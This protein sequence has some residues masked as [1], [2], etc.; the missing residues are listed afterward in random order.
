MPVSRRRR[1]TVGILS[2]S[3]TTRALD[4]LCLF[5]SHTCPFFALQATQFG[6]PRAASGQAA[7]WAPS[8]PA[9]GPK[10]GPKKGP[11]GPFWAKF[12]ILLRREFFIY[13]HPSSRYGRKILGFSGCHGARNLEFRESHGRPKKIGLFFLMLNRKSV[14]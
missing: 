2:C 6:S 5:T 12:G 11:K 4:H 3:L 10:F 8:K 9:W 13:F 14:V 1:R 7:N